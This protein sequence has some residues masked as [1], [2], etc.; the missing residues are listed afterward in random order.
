[1]EQLT[2]HHNEDVHI[3]DQIDL[4]SVV[5]RLQAQVSKMQKHHAK[6]IVTL[7]HENAHLQEAHRSQKP[8]ANLPRGE[9]AESTTALA[10]NILTMPKRVNTP[11]KANH[12]KHC[13]CHCNRGHFMEECSALKEKIGELIKLDHLKNSSTGCS[14]TGPREETNPNLVGEEVENMQDGQ[15]GKGAEAD[16]RRK[17]RD[18]STN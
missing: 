7:R 16:P 12:S 11:P 8:E 14:C 3:E 4:S 9:E 15:K 1:M 17:K 5:R 13:R 18:P 10:V 2:N 6:E